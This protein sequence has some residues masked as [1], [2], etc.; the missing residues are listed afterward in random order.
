M[1]KLIHIALL[2]VLILP[3]SL[4]LGEIEEIIVTAEK[5]EQ[6]LQDIPIAMSAFPA[7]LIE[8]ARIQSLQDIAAKA[9]N[10]VIGQ[11]SPTQPELT[12]RGI[13]STDREAGSDRS[14]IVFVDEVA[15]GR[16]G[17]STFDLFD[18]ERIEVL[19]GP[20]GTLYGRNVVG[21]AINLITAK[22]Q[23]TNFAK[24]QATVGSESRIEIRGLLNGPISDS[25]NGKIAYSGKSRDGFYTNEKFDDV[26]SNATSNQSLRGQIHFLLNPKDD[27][28]LSLSTSRDSVKGVASKV[29]Q[30][31]VTDDVFE[32][33]LGPFGPYIPDADPFVVDNNELG[34]IN[35]TSQ[36][37]SAIMSFERGLGTWTLI[38]AYR[39]NDL[40]ENRDIA[41]LGLSGSGAASKG[42]ES[43][44]I[45]EEAYEF[46][47]LEARLASPEDNERFHWVMGIYFL[48]ETIDREQIRERQGNNSF[49]RPLFDQFIETSSQAVFGQATYSIT[50]QIDLTAGARYTK[51]DKSFD[52]A[53]VDTLSEE[54]KITIEAELGKA[55]SLKPATEEYT[56]SAEDSWS[57]FTPKVT[58]DF[59]PS[60]NFLFYTSWSQGF[61]S[62]GFSGL[63]ATKSLAEIAFK[64]ETVDSLELGLKW[65][66]S[67]TQINLSYFDMDFNELQLRDRQLLIPGDETSA[68]VTIVNAGEAIINGVE[69]ELRFS[70]VEALDLSASFSMLNT[71]ITQVNEG[72][73]LIVGTE[74]PRAPGQIINV[75]AEY[76][77]PRKNGLVTFRLD[78][79]H[80][81]DFSFDLITKGVQAQYESGKTA[82]FEEGYGL[83]DARI[84]F[85]HEQGEWQL[86]LWGKNLVD[87]VYRTHVQSISSGRVGI[88]QIGDPRTVGLTWT[89][90]IDSF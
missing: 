32:A 62:G 47:S 34:Y 72:S 44:A 12:I 80:T 61:K 35:R 55:P 60:D 68:V 38:P 14:V 49:S 59:K 67:K 11:Q 15:I 17:A 79:R 74:L 4:V 81:G 33:A 88:S 19:R 24:V 5:R 20:Q 39:R 69:A 41:G 82:G 56:A 51:D 37:L 26:N 27:I 25:I 54:E 40:S 48:N 90:S 8:K 87:E 52:M 78:Y 84:Q 3:S 73:N 89:K 71:E 64:P 22:P 10:F 1:Q 21:G 63:A 45:N 9:P 76:K 75:S 6:R 66:G 70:P 2:A 28:L 43:T 31:L 50:E 29:T 83:L 18:L 7:E 16:A 23:D 86:A 36:A 77:V 57:E 85:E 46:L 58:L 42:F 13:G 30:G 65:T 53:V